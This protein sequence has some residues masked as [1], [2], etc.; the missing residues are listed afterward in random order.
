VWLQAGNKE[1]QP[2][3]QQQQQQQQKQQQQQQ[4][5]SQQEERIE[6]QQPLNHDQLLTWQQA[7]AQQAEDHRQRLQQQFQQ[8]LQ[9]LQA[10]VPS[11]LGHLV[12][13]IDNIVTLPDVKLSAG[14][15]VNRA[16]TL[17]LFTNPLC[18]SHMLTHCCCFRSGRTF[19]EVSAA[20]WVINMAIPFAGT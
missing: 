19:I 13:W 8:Q 20:V 5:P 15:A 10:A 11:A 18:V 17:L 3:Q 2:Q 12:R 7:A 9:K 4:Q 6:T 1:E 14:F 16:A